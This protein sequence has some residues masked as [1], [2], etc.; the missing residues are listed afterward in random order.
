MAN[1]NTTFVRNPA[2]GQLNGC[3]AARWCHEWH[4]PIGLHVQG[5]ETD[6]QTLSREL[7][8]GLCLYEQI[9]NDNLW[10]YGGRLAA[11][12]SLPSA[13]GNCRLKSIEESAAVGEHFQKWLISVR[14]KPSGP[15][16]RKGICPA[17]LMLQEEERVTPPS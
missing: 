10:L 8:T 13:D 15:T 1:A 7:S 6:L 14:H 3:L 5:A 2:A 16:S 11:R 12:F 17:T 4:L 9:E